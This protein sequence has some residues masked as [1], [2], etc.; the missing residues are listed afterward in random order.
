VTAAYPSGREIDDVT[1]FSAEIAQR[2]R[3]GDAGLGDYLRLLKPRVMSLVVFTALAA[4]V[5]A[6]GGVHPV[7]GLACLVCIAA[8]AGA[9][10]ALNMWWD[11][12]ID[13]RMARTALRP[14]PA[15]RVEGEEA[16][17]LGLGLA[18]LSV[19]MLA[20]F[21]NLLAA[22]LLAFTIF[23]YA[24]VYTMLLKRSTPQNIVIGGAAGAFP[25][26]IGWAAA[27]GEI[28]AAPLLMFAVIFLWTPPHFWA[29][30]LYRNGDYARAKVP[31]L[32]VVAGEAAT[33]RQVLLYTLALSA[34]A[35][36]PA[37]TVAGGPVYLSVTAVAGAVFLQSAWTVASRSAAEARADRYA[38]EKR[39]FGLS[40]LYLFVVFGAFMAEAVAGRIAGPL[41]AGWPVWF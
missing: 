27:T 37:F 6:P 4:I 21:A 28:G 3:T 22:A 23:F 10:G 12:D 29:L 14:I 36:L 38:A 33:R 7:V 9:A 26:M 40:I 34:V 8:G 32:P 39:L 31:M 20:V 5:A 24:V 25:P 16:L 35:I 11:S 15:G 13:R 1:G 19:S 41:V 30:A 2:S 18:L 17:G